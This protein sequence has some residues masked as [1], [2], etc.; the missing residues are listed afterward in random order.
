MSLYGANIN[1][2]S[3]PSPDQEAREALH[4]PGLEWGKRK[5]ELMN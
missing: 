2:S 1:K 4:I 3:S 5:L